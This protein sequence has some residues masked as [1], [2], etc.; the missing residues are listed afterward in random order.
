M[1]DADETETPT[2]TKDGP[3]CQGHVGWHEALAGTGTVSPWCEY[4]WGDICDAYEKNREL[5]S[6]TPA[7]W[8]D[9]DFAG[10][11]WGETW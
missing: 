10:E 11:S 7:S 8:F 6:D 5:L 1:T 2:C 9:P 3:E 4:H